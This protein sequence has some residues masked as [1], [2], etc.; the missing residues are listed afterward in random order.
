MASPR[1]RTSKVVGACEKASPS[2][3]IVYRNIEELEVDPQ[4]PR[5]H[6]EKQIQQIARSIES[7][8][9]N[10]PFL[11]DHNSRLIAGHGRLAAC[12]FLHLSRVPTIALEHLSE[13]QMRAFQIADNRITEIATWDKRLLAEQLKSLSELELNFTLEAIGFRMA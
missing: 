9:F 1:K 10:V 5:L 7:F 12:K 2:L 4:N 8:G 11:I 3:S 13:S 6:S